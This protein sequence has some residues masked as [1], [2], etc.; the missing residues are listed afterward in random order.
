MVT[1]YVR[2]AYEPRPAYRQAW[3]DGRPY[4]HYWQLRAARE[5]L[6]SIG[7]PF[8]DL[9][10]TDPATVKVP[11]EDEIRAFTAKLEEAGPPEDAG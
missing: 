6:D 2:D 5:L 9:P 10:V 4:C 11:L 3:G 8:P 7:E 1:A